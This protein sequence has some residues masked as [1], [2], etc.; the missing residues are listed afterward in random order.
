MDSFQACLCCPSPVSSVSLQTLLFIFSINGHCSRVENNQARKPG[1]VPSSQVLFLS[2]LGMRGEE[3]WTPLC[4]KWLCVPNGFFNVCGGFFAL[5]MLIAAAGGEK[6]LISASQGCSE[7]ET[8]PTMLAAACAQ[9]YKNLLQHCT[10]ATAQRMVT[11]CLWVKHRNAISEVK[12]RS[13]G[14]GEGWYFQ[15]NKQKQ[16]HSFFPPSIRFANNATS[17]KL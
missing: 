4:S 9:R 16:M 5:W 8:R 15:K 10:R 14:L 7:G 1:F 13:Y 2:C 6:H 17:P 12:G 11:F 3:K